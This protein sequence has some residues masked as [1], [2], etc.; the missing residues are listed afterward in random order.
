[1]S[2][3]GQFQACLFFLMKRFH[4][5]K[6]TSQ[7]KMNQQNK[8]KKN[9]TIFRRHTKKINRLEI[10]LITSFHYT[11]DVHPYQPTYRASIYTHLF[12]FVTICENIF[13][14]PLIDDHL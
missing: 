4:V 8:I 9:A 1:M 13:E 14:S 10:V 2:L 11:T 12:L 5:H 6:N 3:S 7:A